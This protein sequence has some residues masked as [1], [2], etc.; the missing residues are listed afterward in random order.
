MDQ[1]MYSRMM[2]YI[3]GTGVM[4]V[5]WQDAVA[6]LKVTA[7]G[8]ANRQISL[9]TGAAWIQGHYYE[10]DAPLLFNLGA[11]SATGTR[12]DLLVLECIWGRQSRDSRKDCS[13]N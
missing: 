11:N 8:G 5:P 2:R 3:L 12:A 10:N 4:S 1:G 9:D 13:R 7:T 6:E